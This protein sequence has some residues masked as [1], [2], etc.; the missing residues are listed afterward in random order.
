MGLFHF[1]NALKP[2]FEKLSDN[3]NLLMAEIHISADEL[4]RRTGL[5]ASTIKK[6]RNRYNPNPTLA[7]L[8]PLAQFFSVTLGQLAG[9]EPLSDIR[10]KGIYKEPT[11]ILRHIPLLSWD[12]AIVWPNADPKSR[13]SISTEHEYSKNAYA[14]MVEEDDW[15]NL[16][17][18]TILIVDPALKAEHRDYVINYMEGHTLPSLKQILYDEGQIYLKPVVQ[19]YNISAFTAKHRI[20]GVVMEYKKHLKNTVKSAHLFVEEN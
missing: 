8:L 5:P 12:E 6:I 14:L 9:D 19:G 15:E 2:M 13:T 1:R 18:G 11:V 17:R 10:V 16:T 20:L 7:T 4:A 3:L